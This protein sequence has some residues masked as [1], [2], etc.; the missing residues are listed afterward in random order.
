MYMNRPM[1]SA[2]GVQAPAMVP[3]RPTQLGY[4]A[5]PGMMARPAYAPAQSPFG[6]T[7]YAPTQTAYAT[8]YATTAQPYGVQSYATNPMFTSSAPTSSA[9]QNVKVLATNVW[10]GVVNMVKSL[11]SALGL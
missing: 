8:P 7:A 6:Q 5:N 10:N 9:L 1:S 2:Y 11:F 3:P 4:A